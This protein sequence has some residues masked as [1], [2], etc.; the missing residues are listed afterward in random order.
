MKPIVSDPFTAAA[1]KSKKEEKLDSEK[2]QIIEEIKIDQQILAESQAIDIE[3][4]TNKKVVQ[5][6]IK[7]HFISNGSTKKKKT[8]KED[9]D[10]EEDDD[11]EE[12]E[13]SK[14]KEL[15]KYDSNEFKKPSNGKDYNLKMV[16]FNVNGIR[17][18]I[19]VIYLN[20]H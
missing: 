11:E 5:P 4:A 1:K 9:E 13:K 18:S 7:N 6:K 2:E 19:E 12:N 3:D 17:A 15:P 8:K 14:Q 16:T 20:F 10:D